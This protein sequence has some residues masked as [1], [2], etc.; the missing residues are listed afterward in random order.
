LGIDPPHRRA[1]LWRELK[2]RIL[3]LADNKQLLPVW[4]IDLC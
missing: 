2:A 3:D 4:V 1:A